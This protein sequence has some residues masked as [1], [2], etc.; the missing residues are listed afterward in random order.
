MT[1]SM[2]PK[3][4]NTV[5][6]TLKTELDESANEEKTVAFSSDGLD[7]HDAARSSLYDF[8]VYFLRNFKLCCETMFVKQ[9]EYIHGQI[10]TKAAFKKRILD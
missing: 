7:C 10:H 9:I 2:M 1:R 6:K 5:D 3:M 8:S 4:K